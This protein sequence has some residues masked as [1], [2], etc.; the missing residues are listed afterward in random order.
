M[1]QYLKLVAL[2]A[3]KKIAIRNHAIKTPYVKAN[4]LPSY[5]PNMFWHKV[6]STNQIWKFIVRKQF[7]CRSN[8]YGMYLKNIF[9]E[10]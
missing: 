8:K 1:V 3:D 10:W 6:K 9:L 2:F 7:Y 4:F 5:H